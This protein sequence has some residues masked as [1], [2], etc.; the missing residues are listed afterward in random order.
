MIHLLMVHIFLN[1]LL[2]LCHSC[3]LSILSSHSLFFLFDSWVLQMHHPC[4]SYVYVELLF[5]SLCLWFHPSLLYPLFPSFMMAFLCLDVSSMIGD[6]NFVK[7]LVGWLDLLLHQFGMHV[8]LVKWL[9]CLPQFLLFADPCIS[10]VGVLHM[11]NGSIIVN[12]LIYLLIQ[13][14]CS[15]FQSGCAVDSETVP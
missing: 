4:I 10:N 1:A 9:K 13:H 5:T 6:A 3:S 2:K 12:K 8:Y 7:S 11:K 14:T 15:F